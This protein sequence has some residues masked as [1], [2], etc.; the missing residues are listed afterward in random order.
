MAMKSILCLY[1]LRGLSGSI[2]KKLFNY[3]P[4]KSLYYYQSVNQCEV[5]DLLTRTKKGDDDF[6]FFIIRACCKINPDNIIGLFN[7]DPGIV[8]KSQ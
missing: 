5:V 1:T 6:F 2:G 8:Y 4:L 3:F 7:V